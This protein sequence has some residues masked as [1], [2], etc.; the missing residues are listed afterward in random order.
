MTG[1]AVL[2]AAKGGAARRLVQ[3]IVIFLVLTAAAAAG[4]LGLTLATNADAQ[5]LGAFTSQHGAHLAVT[6]DVAKVTR[7][8]LART[9]H[10]PGVTRAAGPTLRPPS[11]SPAAPPQG[12][13]PGTATRL[14]CAPK[15]L[16]GSRQVPQG[17]RRTAAVPAGSRPARRSLPVVESA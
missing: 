6:I 1:G 12:R 17:S 4:T 15:A 7:A 13:R 5:F 10:L 16:Q 8:Q 11:S 14:A 2:T 3:T 9:A